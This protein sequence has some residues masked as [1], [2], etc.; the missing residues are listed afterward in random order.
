VFIDQ[1]GTGRSNPLHCNALLANG[2]ASL[3]GSVFP[4][5]H[6][7][8]CR[9]SLSQR[10]DLALYT[11]A[12]ATDDMDEIR[13]WLGYEQVNLYGG[14][15]GT[16]VVQVYMRRHPT[17]VRTA[18]MNGVDPVNRIT[19]LH[20]AVNL[21]IA[22]ERLML[23]CEGDT[24]CAE[25]FPDFRS[26]MSGLIAGFGNGPVRTRYANRWVDFSQ[27]DFAYAVRG[28]LYGSLASRLPL[29]VREAY[30]TKDLS[31]F[32]DY[33]VERSSWVASDD[34]GTGMHLTIMCAEDIAFADDH[35]IRML[36]G[37]TF[38][39]DHL[40][41]QYRNACRRWVQADLPERYRE[42]VTSSVPTLLLSGGRDPVTPAR[43]GAEV[44]ERLSNS[45]HVVV[46]NAG[47]GVGGSCV[48]E[49]QRRLIE[50]GSLTNVDTSCVVSSPPTRFLLRRF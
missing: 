30:R 49:M 22:L 36:S 8:S 26:Q 25:A 43:W 40:I 42:L 31:A 28:M 1:R 33:Y 10:A 44:A 46:P 29:M 4:E 48:A 32:A 11:T 19:Y 35:E 3:F 15:Y 23:E 21:Q 50:D 5:D 2:P 20:G 27:G 18:I 47:H 12:I 7:Q 14:S 45:L 17:R 13:E 37:D 41:Q 16:R 6:I 34:I 39:R 9:D 24:D 38:M